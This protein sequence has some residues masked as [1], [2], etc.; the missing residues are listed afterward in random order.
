[1]KEVDLL[2]DISLHQ[3]ASSNSVDIHMAMEYQFGVNGGW[4]ALGTGNRM[5]GSLMFIMYPNTNKC[6]STHTTLSTLNQT[7]MNVD[8]NRCYL[9]C[10]R[11]LVSYLWSLLE[12][13]EED[14]LLSFQ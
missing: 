10:S 2:I 5:R 3:N 13:S 7:E 9:E 12:M 1:M 11:S 6:K 8:L 4:V 14:L